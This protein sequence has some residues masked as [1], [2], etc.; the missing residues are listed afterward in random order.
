MC[1]EKKVYVINC[2]YP[3]S[4]FDFRT[5]EYDGDLEGIMQEATRRNSVYSLEDFEEEV[6]N[7]DLI[8]TNSFILI[9]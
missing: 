7:E 1:K 3:G 4:D 6:N 2:S 8:L 5:A 9:R